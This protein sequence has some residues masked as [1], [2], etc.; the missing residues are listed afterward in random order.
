[1][2]NGGGGTALLPGGGGGSA[3]VTRTVY[4]A[5][6]PS[7]AELRST[8]TAARRDA[9][10]AVVEH[11]ARVSTRMAAAPRRRRRTLRERS[12]RWRKCSSRP[13]GPLEWES[14][15]GF[16]VQRSAL[17]LRSVCRSATAAISIIAIL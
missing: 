16:D 15:E 6:I 7:P 3:L 12:R 13:H 11:M 10:R 2:G 4:T 14:P 9:R 17:A 8:D 5:L 1:M